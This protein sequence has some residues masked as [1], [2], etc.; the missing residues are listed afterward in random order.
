MEEA[1]IS[2]ADPYI[3]PEGEN[4]KLDYSLQLAAG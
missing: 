2:K 4:Y 1:D 3:F